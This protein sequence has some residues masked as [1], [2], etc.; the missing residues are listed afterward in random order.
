M[1]GIII[2]KNSEWNMKSRSNCRA[3]SLARVSNEKN[4]LFVIITN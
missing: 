3:P 4:R 1:R 2:D